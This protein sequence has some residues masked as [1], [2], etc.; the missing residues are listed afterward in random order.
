MGDDN[1]ISPTVQTVTDEVPI[2]VPSASTFDMVTR[3]VFRFNMPD[4]WTTSHEL[5]NADFDVFSIIQVAVNAY[6]DTDTVAP[7]RPRGYSVYTAAVI[8]AGEPAAVSNTRDE[9]SLVGQVASTDRSLQPCSTEWVPTV[10]PDNMPGAITRGVGDP[11]PTETFTEPP[12]SML[13]NNIVSIGDT[14]SVPS[15]PQIVISVGVRVDR[16]E[17]G[18]VITVRDIDTVQFLEQQHTYV[19]QQSSTDTT[20]IYVSAVTVDIPPRS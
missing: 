14:D 13:N 2:V 19:L 1:T 12:P 16:G 15:V 17:P 10:V 4:T 11:L 5:S 18:T 7:T 9:V 3:V 20:I 6:G 8:W